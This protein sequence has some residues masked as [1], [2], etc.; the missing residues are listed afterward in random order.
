MPDDL[1]DRDLLAWSRTQAER[2][3]RIARGERVNDVD[4]DHVIEEIEELGRSE[5]RA[6]RSPYAV[7]LLHALK[8]VSWPGHGANRTWQVEIATFLLQARERFEPGMRQHL[9]VAGLYASALR[10]IEGLAVEEP[11][12]QVAEATSLTVEELIDPGLTAAGLVARLRRDAD[13]SA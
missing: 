6:V 4:W 5:L 12:Q 13:A 10:Q 2:L 8:V 9:D 1:Y 11:P 7:A 3:R